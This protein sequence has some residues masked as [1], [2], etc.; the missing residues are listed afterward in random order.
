MSYLP[1]LSSSFIS[2]THLSTSTIVGG[3][4]RD[5]QKGDEGKLGVSS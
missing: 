2:Q 3:R 4:E 5:V 1:T